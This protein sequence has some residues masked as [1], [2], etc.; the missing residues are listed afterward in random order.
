MRDKR[1][2]HVTYRLVLLVK[3]VDVAVEDLDKELNRYGG[4]H[5][6]VRHTQGALQTLEHAFAVSVGLQQC[7]RAATP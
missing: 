2:R 5:A 3:I 7:V 1:P 6:R 4:I